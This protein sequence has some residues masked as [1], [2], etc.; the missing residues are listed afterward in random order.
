[1]KHS[2]C[3]TAQTLIGSRWLDAVT[4]R[5]IVDAETGCWN[6]T[7]AVT[8]GGYGRASVKIGD[9]HRGTSAHRASWIAH[10][11][12]VSPG[13][14]VDHLCR[15]RSCINPDHL[16]PVTR[17]ENNRRRPTNGHVE[18]L[19]VRKGCGEHGQA[20]GYWY[21]YRGRVNYQWLCRIC[22][23]DEQRRRKARAAANFQGDP[24]LDELDKIRI[25]LGVTKTE[26]CRRMGF[27]WVSLYNKYTGRSKFTEAHAKLMADALGVDAPGV[28]SGC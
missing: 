1:M 10:N 13:L 15:N 22:R 3:V 6:W 28:Q 24:V 26:L 16:E 9:R 11:G 4:D 5:Y 7:G 27:S 25:E 14:E 19:E 23:R 12:P 17:A 8:R 18:P 20:D 2:I 21:D